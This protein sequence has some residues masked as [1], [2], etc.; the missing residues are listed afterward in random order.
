MKKFLKYLLIGLLTITQAGCLSTES[1]RNKRTLEVYN[2]YIACDSQED[3]VTGI[4]MNQFAKILEK[5]SK[6]RIK[7]NTYPNSQLGSDTE[8]IEA[9]QN[10]NI[11]FTVGT[12]APQVSFVPQAAIFDA[13]MAFKNLK[14]AR[15]VLD[16]PL[17]EKLK[18]YYE[19]KDF[20]LLAVADQGFRV[21]SSNKDINEIK[22]FKGIKIRTMENKNHIGFWKSVGANP[23]PM[24]WSEV[25]IGLEQGSI[26]A[27][28][29]PIE[30]I[31]ASKIYEKQKYIIN[32]N[33]ILHSLMLVGSK[34]VI[35]D[36]PKD[37]QDIIKESAQKA[38]IFARQATDE[39]AQGRLE[40]MDKYGTVIK[41]LSPKLYKDMKNSSMKIWKDLEKEV[42]KDLIELLKK[43]IEKA[44]NHEN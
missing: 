31:V 42:D 10:G 43:E 11:T 25:F 39:R 23:T 17:T 5:D 19:D 33:H 15:E 14:I 3:T 8:I 38:K 28:E 27:Q 40:I 1:R 12:S 34:K 13:P 6:G 7:V 21:M 24:A 22:D 29:N 37:L 16:G 35:N 20:Y 32:T 9:V 41:D 18:K 4:F 30:L 44:E 2:L 36:L 26:D